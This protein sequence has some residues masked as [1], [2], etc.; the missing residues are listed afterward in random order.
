MRFVVGGVDWLESNLEDTQARH[1]HHA[2]SS[3]HNNLV[4]DGRCSTIL[5]TS[6]HTPQSS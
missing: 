6:N 5:S 2:I 4:Y 1:R 3:P